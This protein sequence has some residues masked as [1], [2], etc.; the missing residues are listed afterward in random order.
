MKIFVTA[1]VSYCISLSGWC[2]NIE[3]PTKNG[4]IWYEFIDSSQSTGKD[5]LT[6]RAK[7][8]AAKAFN[9]YKAVTQLDDTNLGKLILKGST[10]L[11]SNVIL[12]P[13][14]NVYFTIDFSIKDGKYRVSIS[15]IQGH[16]VGLPSLAT[17]LEQIYIRVKSNEY[18]YKSKKEEKYQTEKR[19]KDIQTIQGIDS[20]IRSLLADIK[21]AMAKADDF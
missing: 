11:S 17:T 14:E 21:F 3:L 19:A 5:E 10:R 15:D 16:P 13:I 8:W 6:K 12:A 9:S 7:V 2:Q 1:F 4:N 20:F 18:P